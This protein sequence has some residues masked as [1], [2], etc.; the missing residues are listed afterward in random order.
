MNLYIDMGG[1]YTRYQIDN[2]N[3]VVVKD[4]DIIS[5]LSDIIK[6]YPQIKQVNISFAG[7]VKDNIILSAPNINI[8]N[9]DLH[10]YFPNIKF[11]VENDLN[12]AVLAESNYWKSG[13]IV[14]LYIGTGIGAGVISGGRLINGFSNGAG[15]IGHIPF[16]Q[17]PFLCGCGKD[18]C[19]E[20]FSSGSAILK[21]AEY[22]N[23]DFKTL[24]EL[25]P[26]LYNQFLEGIL[27][28]TSILITL[29]NPQ[30]LVLGGG[31]I[32]KNS[33][34]IDYIQDNISQYAFGSNLKDLEIVQTKL[35]NA[36]LEGCKLFKK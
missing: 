26:N 3:M 25:P 18:N 2:D 11:R 29:F 33:F 8:K 6:K 17:A 15:E 4:R 28:S 16:R 9:L 13:D 1:T 27:Y 24:E 14:A 22:L 36:S 20:L 32:E 30:I 5:L 19:V 7:Q 35:D 23:M 21:W 31:V 12:C 10:S 34:L